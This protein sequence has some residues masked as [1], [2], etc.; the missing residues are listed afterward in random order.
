MSLASAADGTQT[1]SVV[2]DG[3][4]PLAMREIRLE[5]SASSLGD[6]LDARD[7]VQLHH[8]RDFSGHSGVR[9]LHR[10]AAWSPGAEPSGMVSVICHRRTG[11]CIL[12]GA[13]PPF[14][15][16]FVDIAILHAQPHRDGAFGLG[17]HLRATRE[18]DPGEHDVLAHLIVLQGDDGIALLSEYAERM[19]QRLAA[20]QYRQPAARIGGWNSWDYYAGAVQAE[21][22]LANANA[23]NKLFG[24]GLRYV[25]IDEGYERQWG[26]WDAGWKFPQGL[27][28]LCAQIRAEGYEPGIWTAP[29]MVGV[30]TPLY[31]EHPDWFVGDEKGDPFVENAGYGSMVQLDVTHPQVEAHIRKTF[32]RLR[33][34]GFT[35][36]KC[37]FAQL[38]LGASAF[39][40]SRMSHA[41]MIRR[42]FEVIREAIGPDAYLLACGAPYE[43]VIGIADAHRTTGDIHNYWSHIRQNIRS[44]LARWWMQGAVG[45]TD[46]DTAIVRCP[47]TTDDRRLNRR[48]AKNPWGL[49]GGWAAGREM[50]LEEA[51]TL[52]LAC[53]AS[54][55]DL[56]LGDA[57]DKLNGVG[58]GLLAG[59]LRQPPVR[60]GIPLNLFAPDGDELP[61][62]AAETDDPDI[63]LLALFNLGDDYRTQRIPESFQASDLAWTSFWTGEAVPA[64]IAGE[65]ALAPRSAVAWLISRSGAPVL[66]PKARP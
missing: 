10:P 48:L 54:G 34:A 7:Y 16:C 20:L 22:V 17:F 23:A 35:Y 56:L 5:W 57:L 58:T 11:A 25:V 51:K 12:L 49:G 8:A 45:N 65:A 13:L 30:Y 47:D 29:L 38:L 60:R 32:E 44:M 53:Y 52:L 6:R 50:N 26:V 18:L 42:L 55:G 39:H 66:E 46:P 15:D 63:R 41:G 27:D 31:R 28:A 59:L 33:A 24:A 36:F 1:V 62:V 61:V 21:D 37:D 3:P 4:E 2:N 43:A 40:S 19:R 9:P 14:G 64:T